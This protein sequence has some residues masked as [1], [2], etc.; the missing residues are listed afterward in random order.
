MADIVSTSN[1]GY[2]LNQKLYQCVKGLT[3]A[4]SHAPK[5]TASS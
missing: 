1:G 2:P 4:K 5:K 3:A